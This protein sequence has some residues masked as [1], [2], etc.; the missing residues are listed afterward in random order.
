MKHDMP[1]MQCKICLTSTAQKRKP[2]PGEARRPCGIA[3]A[4]KP[5]DLRGAALWLIAR[6]DDDDDAHDPAG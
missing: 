5:S 4:G 3:A 6:H 2:A 1:T